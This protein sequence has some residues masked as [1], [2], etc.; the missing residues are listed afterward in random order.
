MSGT[1]TNLPSIP[2]LD[3]YYTS[4]TT[5]LRH[6]ATVP[7]AGGTFTTTVPANCV[8]T[9]NGYHIPSLAVSLLTTN[10]ATSVVLSWTGSL[11]NYAL[12]STT[13]LNLPSWIPPTNAPQPDGGQQ[14]VTVTP[15][16]PQQFFRLHRF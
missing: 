7:I 6:S 15:A 13:N 11:T 10:E 1:L 9:L 14:S 12:E 8:F 2:S 16:V 3:L 5:N 4:S